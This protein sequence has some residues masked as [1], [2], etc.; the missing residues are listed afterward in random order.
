[1]DAETRK[2]IIQDSRRIR[3]AILDVAASDY[4]TSDVNSNFSRV[5]SVLKGVLSGP[6]DEK[7]KVWAVYFYKH[8]DSILAW[9]S[10]RKLEK[11]GI[12]SR[13]H[14][15]LNYLEILLSMIKEEEDGRVAQG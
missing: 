14:D 13:I 9:L 2:R 11:E 4:G 6:A 8:V 1:M 7:Y 5:G 15:C 12:E 10:G 3:D